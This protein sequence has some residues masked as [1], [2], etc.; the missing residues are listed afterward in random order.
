MVRQILQH[1]FIVGAGGMAAVQQL[2]QQRTSPS[3]LEIAVDEFIPALP[4]ALRHLGVAVTRQ[5]DQ[6]D[7]AHRIKVDGSRLARRA[8]HARQAFTVAQLID[9]RG[10]S[11]I[12][13]PG[14]NNLRAV[15]FRQLRRK[16]VGRLELGFRRIHACLLTGGC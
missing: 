11:H 8:A 3:A 7:A 4:F 13:A 9:Q 14:K 12:R 15:P 5:I 10:L 16:A 2:H 1:H 6:I